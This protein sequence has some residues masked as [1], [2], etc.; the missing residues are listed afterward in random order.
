MTVKKRLDVLVVER[1]IADSRAKAQAVIAAGQLQVNGQIIDKCGQQVP[2]NAEICLLSN[3]CPYVSRGGLKLA[4]ALS[5]FQ[6][7]VNG[8]VCMDVGA[9]TGGFTDCLLQHGAERVYAVDVGYGQL[10]WKI[11][12]NGR[13]V[14]LERQNIRSMDPT[15]IPEPIDLLVM[16]VSF[17]SLKTALP[18]ALPFLKPCGAVIAL[19]KPQ[20]EAGR[21]QVGKGG[22]IRNAG[23]REEVVKGLRTFFSQGL[24]LTIAGLVTSPIH[25][26]KG[27]EEYLIYMKMNGGFSQYGGAEVEL[28]GDR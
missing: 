23:V 9:S 7:S 13:V 21:E 5:C 26:A 2:V 18:P 3:P 11:R 6:I 27:N 12:N 15:L 24:R 19:I 16:D 17:I 8:M 14:V 4:H 25:G 22:V 1:G 20:F 28:E 10:D